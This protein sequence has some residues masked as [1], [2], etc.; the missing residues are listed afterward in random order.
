MTK[1]P[2]TKPL[3]AVAA[4]ATLLALAAT[5]PAH[6]LAPENPFSADAQSTWQTNGTV[7]ALASAKGRVFAGGTFSQVRPPGTA[8][9]H[10]ASQ[11]SRS[12]VVLDAA[13]GAPVTD[14]TV[15]VTLSTATPTVRSL[16]A[17]GA[18]LSL[19][20]TEATT[21]GQAI[22][23]TDT[24]W[25]EATMTWNTGRPARTSA[26]TIGNFANMPIARVSTPVTGITTSG[27]VSFELSPESTDAVLVSSSEATNPDHRPQ[28]ILT[29][30]S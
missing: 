24:T 14:C 7:W 19:N 29:I 16:A 5:T 23:R 22:F 13:T 18:R 11:D 27:D 10:A 15:N 25:D 1:H 6:A 8:V 2:V 17:T 4:G 3:A 20:V 12:L 9:G 28:L 21:N 30:S 26:T